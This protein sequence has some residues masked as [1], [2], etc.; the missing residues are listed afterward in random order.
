M[1]YRLICL[2]SIICLATGC[3]TE[4]ETTE[5][6]ECSNKDRT[7]LTEIPVPQVTEKNCLDKKTKKKFQ[8]VSL[9]GNYA[10][11]FA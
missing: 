9:N 7:H 6:Q 1:L 8:T 2:M 3:S 5:T 10:I 11:H 4:S